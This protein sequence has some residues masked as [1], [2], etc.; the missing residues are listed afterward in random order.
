M[1][2]YAHRGASADF[3]EMT[4]AAYNAAVE[5]GADGFECDVR[6]SADGALVL[7]HNDTMLERA[8]HNGRISKMTLAE[9]KSAY[10]QAIT[11]DDFL[12][13]AVAAG[14]GVLIE[15]K[16]PVK[17]GNKVEREVVKKLHARNIAKSIDVNVMSFSW[18]AVEKVKRLD[19]TLKTTFLIRANTPWILV[20]SSSASHIGPGINDVRVNPDILGKIQKLGK[21]VSVWTVDRADDAQLCKK[22]GVENLITNTPRLAR[23]Y[24]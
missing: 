10:P 20:K 3:P 7:W 6:L 16:H 19:P 1:K 17:S 9:I 4:A 23:T 2:I 14:K 21:T 18:I 12:D 24:L 5:Q 11:L 15:T 13:I 22:L 8:G